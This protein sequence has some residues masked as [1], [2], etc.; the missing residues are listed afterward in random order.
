MSEKLSEKE[1]QKTI[2]QWLNAQ[3][4]IFAWQNNSTGVYDPVK[5]TFRTT[6]ALK[7]VSDILGVHA[8]CG[9]KLIALEVKTPERH[10]RVSDDQFLF[11]ENV[12][13][14]G[15]IAGVVTSVE[16]A[17]EILEKAEKQWTHTFAQRAAA[18]ER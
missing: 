8:R 10:T 5:K 15:G 14:L 3:A 6:Q 11:L 1:I 13:R 16:D 17:H 18:P 4:G 9:G 2:L 7:G 12:K